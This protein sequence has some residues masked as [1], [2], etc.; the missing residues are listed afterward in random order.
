MK[1][2]TLSRKNTKTIPQGIPQ[3]IPLGIP[4]SEYPP[5]SNYLILKRFFSGR[6][7]TTPSQRT[8]GA[9]GH[10]WPYFFAFFYKTRRGISNGI[11]SYWLK[12]TREKLKV[13][14]TLILRGL[15]F[16][17]RHSCFR[18]GKVKRN[19]IHSSY[20]NLQSREDFTHWFIGVLS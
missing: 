14:I 18:K 9:G 6:G 20:I 13:C 19:K 7:V 3:P 16:K 17:L 4:T 11:I 12:V 1:H 5:P 15:I 2:K 10:S 8:V